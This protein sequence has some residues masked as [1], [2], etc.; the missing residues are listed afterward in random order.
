MG[1]RTMIRGKLSTTVRLLVAGAAVLIPLLSRADSVPLVGDT[2]INAG[3]SLN[4]GNLPTIN[5]GGTSGSQGLLLFDLSAFP[6]NGPVAWAK[7]RV[8]VD[9]VTTPGALDLYAAGATW[10]EAAVNGTS[11]VGPGSLIQAGIPVTTAG[12]Y[13]TLDVTAQVQAW[14]N[15]SPNTGFFLNPNPASTTVFLDAKENISTSQAATLEVVMLGPAGAIGAPGPAGAAGLTGPTGPFGPTGPAGATGA[16]GLAGPV[17][18][19]GATGPPGPAGPTGAAGVAGPTG[20]T[21]AVGATGAQGDPGAQGAVGLAGAAGPNGPAGAIGPTGPA[22]I[23]GN[24][25]VA[26]PTGAVGPAGPNGPAGATGAP[27]VVGAVGPTGPTGPI[28]FPGAAGPQGPAGATGPVGAN[29]GNVFSV[30]TINNGAII[31]D[32]DTHRIFFVNNSGGDATV[33]LPHANSASGK[34]MIFEANTFTFTSTAITSH[35]IILKTQDGD[36]IWLPSGQTTTSGL[37]A[38]S[39]QGSWEVVS[40]GVSRWVGMGRSVAVNPDGATPGC[41]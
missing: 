27:G 14:I 20:P 34:V 4:F 23:Q 36:R 24:P 25:G 19:V 35:F 6:A 10:V 40:D 2:F 13:I 3:S 18:A 1:D 15:G 29:F 41:S 8:Y 21:G 30:T 12:S 28:G 37:T 31:P 16:Q 17:G 7:L 11:G 39:T 22:G 9:K 5:L 26:G 33:T 32:T 38:C